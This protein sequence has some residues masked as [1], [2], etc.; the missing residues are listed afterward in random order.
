[1]AGQDQCGVHCQLPARRD[2]EN[3]NL[4]TG[5]IESKLDSLVSSDEA[6]DGIWQNAADFI[7]LAELEEHDDLPMGFRLNA[8]GVLATTLLHKGQSRTVAAASSLNELDATGFVDPARAVVFADGQAF[9]FERQSRGSGAAAAGDG[10]IVAPMPGKV[11][12]VDV[13]EGDTVTAGQRLMV[14]EAMKMEH[15]LTA[16]FNGTVTDLSAAAGSQ[17]QVEAVLC[18]VEPVEE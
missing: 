18:V 15:A 3:A 14:L 13:A 1:M 7:A 9:A 12:A 4:D 5:F 2:F 16:P 11:I 10:A 17:V 8:P 6:D